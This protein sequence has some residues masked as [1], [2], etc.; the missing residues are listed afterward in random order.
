[1]DLELDDRRALCSWLPEMPARIRKQTVFVEKRDVQRSYK[2]LIL[3]AGDFFQVVE[4][5]T[6]EGR[7]VLLDRDVCQGRMSQ[8]DKKKKESADSDTSTAVVLRAPAERW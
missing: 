6:I 5:V 2:G 3:D 1:M 4:S 7:E 8:E